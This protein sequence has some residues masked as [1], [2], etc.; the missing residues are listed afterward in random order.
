M[1]DRT[2]TYVVRGLFDARDQAIMMDIG[3]AQR[4]FNRTGRLDRIEVSLPKGADTAAWIERLRRELPTGVDVH[5]RGLAQDQNRKM[6]TGFRWNLRALSYI[7]LVVGAFLIYNAIA[8]SVVRRRGEIGI[9]R[10]IGVSAN[11]VLLIFLGEAS[12]LGLVGSILGIALGRGLA[13]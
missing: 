4:V 12:M 5:L 6:L 7:S 11:G 13:A 10:A 8:V 2:E 1:N 9:L 3:L